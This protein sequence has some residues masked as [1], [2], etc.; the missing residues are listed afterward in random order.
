MMEVIHEDSENSP[1]RY[2]QQV[3]F[4]DQNNNIIDFYNPA[5]V[6]EED[7]QEKMDQKDFKMSLT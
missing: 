3:N 5:I 2:E 1:I 7:A 4:S 6:P